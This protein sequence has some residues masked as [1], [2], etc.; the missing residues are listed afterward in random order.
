[1]SGMPLFGELVEEPQTGT[2][3]PVLFDDAY[4][5]CGNSSPK[6]LLGTALRT[7]R[8]TL[9]DI[10]VYVVS[11][12]GVPDVLLSAGENDNKIDENSPTSNTPL[13]NVLLN[14][15]TEKVFCLT[16]LRAVSGKQA[17]AG[18]SESFCKIAGVPKEEVD[19]CTNLLPASIPKGSELCFAVRP[20]QGQVTVAGPL[21]AG[22]GS[23]VDII[24]PGLCR[25]LHEVYF[26]PQAIIQGLEMSMQRQFTLLTSNGYSSDTSPFGA[27]PSGTDMS[28]A[29]NYCSVSSEVGC[30]DAS[31]SEEVPDQFDEPS[32]ATISSGCELA[33]DRSVDSPDQG[34]KRSWKERSGRATGSDGYKFGDLARTLVQKTRGRSGSAISTDGNIETFLAESWPGALVTADEDTTWVAAS[35]IPTLNESDLASQHLQGALYKHHTSPVRGRFVP[36]W[37]LRYYELKAGTLRYRRRSGGKVCG[38]L[39]LDGAHVVAEAPKL[40]RMG[41]F[42]V[43]R[44]LSGCQIACELSCSNQDEAAKWVLSIAAA[45]AHFQACRSGSITPE[46]PLVLGNI[47]PEPDPEHDDGGASQPEAS[48]LHKTEASVVPSMTDTRS[49]DG[50]RLQACAS[51]AHRGYA[52]STLFDRSVAVLEALKLFRSPPV[53]AL[54]LALIVLGIKVRRRRRLH[55]S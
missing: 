49:P 47:T 18:L 26:G 35:S 17:A 41:E 44:V 55:A 45:C 4:D 36:Q 13:S 23:K 46:Q 22:A 8:I 38:E 11:I 20:S 39:H 54:L 33:T 53:F 48:G 30:V 19:E 21:I 32:L 31:R 51:L 37:T 24:A 34:Q 40:S 10:Q 43:F 3:F 28:G 6:V 29:D 42:Y 27:T 2:L 7:K 14:S 16:F 50:D 52:P 1:M 12:Y 15:T 5:I 25:G 9:L